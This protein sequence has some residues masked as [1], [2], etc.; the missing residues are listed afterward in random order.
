MP[1]R[2]SRDRQALTPTR[3]AE[4]ALALVEEAG[5]AALNMRALAE[6]LDTGQASLYAHVRNRTDL[7][8]LMAD[9]AWSERK[10]VTDGSWREQ[11]A[12]DAAETLRVAAKYPGLAAASFATVRASDD[13]M[14]AWNRRIGLL[15]SLG[16]ELRQALAA[17]LAVAILAAGRSMEDAVIAERIAE[18]GLTKQEWWRR[19]RET[20]ATDHQT[21]DNLASISDWLTPEDRAAMSAELVEI[22]LDGIQARYGIPTD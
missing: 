9:H 13:Y 5:Y 15:R 18:S 17:D 1:S 3:I 20:V 12:S 21:R 14:D 19:V 10:T 7:D 2:R 11:L 8:R 22:V 16:L 6:R 4:A